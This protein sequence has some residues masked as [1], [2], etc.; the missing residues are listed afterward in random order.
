[1]GYSFYTAAS[2]SVSIP[3]GL[4][5]FCWLATIWDGRPRF[6]VPMLYVVG[7]IFTFVIG[8]LTGVIIASVP[9]DLELHD[10][11]FI[12][13]HFHYVLIG[14]AVFPL[15]GI[16]TYW[17]PKITGRMMSETLGKIGFWMIFL[18]FQL[19]FFPMHF[20]GLLGMPRRV[21]T[22]PAGLGLEL[23]NLLSSIGA[24]IVAAAV[25]LFVINGVVSLYRG[26]IA[27]PNPW[28]AASLEWATS[29]PP[30]VYNFEHIPVVESRTPLWDQQGEFPVVTGLRVDD[31]ETLLTTVVAAVPDLREPVPEASLWPLIA[32]I[33]TAVLFIASIFSPWA[34]PFGAVPGAIAL[35]AWFWP[36][37]MKRHPEPV[38]S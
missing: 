28:D 38:I 2:M 18:G 7:F 3:T 15:L 13:A 34:I 16:L 9:L 26:A 14:G 4:Q 35:I 30:P 33:A 6:T 10:T 8:G 17:Y 12:V 32:A 11:Y 23:P 31:K 19:T 36:K 20:S 21:Y 5:I 29:S 25:L 27:P 37:D 1:V 22:Y 24:F